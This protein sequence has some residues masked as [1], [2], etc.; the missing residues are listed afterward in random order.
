MPET[1]GL[2]PAAADRH[3]KG[4]QKMHGLALYI[5]HVWEA[6]ATTDTSLCREHGLEVD[7]E[8]IALELAPALAAIRT[9]DLEVIR[10]SQSNA[11]QH[12][13]DA[14]LN[15]DPQGRVVRGLVLARNA[16]IHLPA[17]LDLHVDRV[18]GEGPTGWRVMPTWQ[19]YDALPP[20]VRDSTGT[21]S[22]SHRAYRDTVGGRLIV[23]TLL[24]AFAFLLRCDPTLAR[25]VPGTDDLAYFP[26]HPYTLHDYERRHPKQPNRD[27][28]AAEVRRLTEEAVPS[29]SHREISYRL[30]SDGTPVYCGYTEESYGVR[31]SFTEASTQ[32]VRD[33]QA[34]Y[35]YIAVAADGTHQVV[36]ADSDGRL[37]ADGDLLE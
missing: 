34:G 19:P 31:T 27:E 35:R 32:I 15:T 2:F 24:D 13:Y 3:A 28:V 4:R 29:G 26:L 25:R 33:I 11:D 14:L 22:S 17:T 6:T 9:L 5:S 30:D 12:R 1:T 7:S 18:V 10:N 36:T 23:E 21:A 37:H 20:D 16:D 8:R